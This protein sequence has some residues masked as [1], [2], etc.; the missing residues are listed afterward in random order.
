MKVHFIPPTEPDRVAEMEALIKARPYAAL[1]F[2]RVESHFEVV[3]LVP[4]HANNSGTPRWH[5][6]WLSSKEEGAFT[7]GA[8]RS[9]AEVS[10]SL[11][12]GEWRYQPEATMQVQA[13]V[14]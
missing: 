13:G 2:T 5:W 4:D 11:V 6:V 7:D 1:I 14:E 9:L 10:K 12:K 8:A 3:A